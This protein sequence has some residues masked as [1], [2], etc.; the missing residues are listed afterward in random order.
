MSEASLYALSQ[1]F[2]LLARRDALVSSAGDYIGGRIRP[3]FERAFQRCS[4]FLDLLVDGDQLRP[5]DLAWLARAQARAQKLRPHTR[6]LEKAF[7]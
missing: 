4:E 6:E 5:Q 7:A 3:T 1:R 2:R